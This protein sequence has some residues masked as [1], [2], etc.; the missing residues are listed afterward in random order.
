M[1]KEKLVENIMTSGFQMYKK[2]SNGINAPGIPR[3]QFELLYSISFE[4]GKPMKYYGE[5]LMIS[6]PNLSV[7]ADRLIEQDY[8]E[9]IFDPDD[10]R[11][12]ILK[13]TKVGQEFLN[14]QVKRIKE[15]MLRGFDSLTNEDAQR[16][17]EII[18]EMKYIFNK[19]DKGEE[20]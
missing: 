7:M 13:V 14:T 6:K 4:N 5:K 3:S 17:S 10:R 8:V 2:L 11:I 19:L 15:E 9:R 16:L 1:N 18:D 12:I 20:L